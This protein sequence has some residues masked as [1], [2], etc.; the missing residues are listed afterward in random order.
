MSIRSAASQ[1]IVD[2]FTT[3][4][5]TTRGVTSGANSFAN[6]SEMLEVH[7]LTQLISMRESEEERAAVARN[8]TRM[9]LAEHKLDH[10]RRL[11]KDPEL[12]AAYRS[13][14][15]TADKPALAAAE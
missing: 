3:V 13:I 1:A 4:S 6:Y 2:T 10:N 12:E 14:Q 8:N 5:A 15:F 11:A 9:R 7:S